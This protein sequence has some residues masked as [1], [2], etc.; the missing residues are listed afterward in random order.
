LSSEFLR[1]PNFDR[2]LRIPVRIR[3]CGAVARYAGRLVWNQHRNQ[4]LLPHSHDHDLVDEGDTL[5]SLSEVAL[6]PAP[7]VGR[8]L[9]VLR[10]RPFENCS[11]LESL[12]DRKVFYAVAGIALVSRRADALT[13]SSNFEHIL[14]NSQTFRD[15]QAFG[16]GNLIMEVPLHDFVVIRSAHG[17]QQSEDAPNYGDLAVGIHKAQLSQYHQNFDDDDNNEGA[18]ALALLPPASSDIS[19]YLWTSAQN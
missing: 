4:I 11:S 6:A 10:R 13:F 1:S 2:N 5:Y 16:Y 8:F 14:V 19:P 15:P 12:K 17:F 3:Q 18:E 7:G 9:I